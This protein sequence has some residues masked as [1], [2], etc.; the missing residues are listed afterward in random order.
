M[1]DLVSSV[2]DYLTRTD[3]ASS[4]TWGTDFEITLLAHMLDTIVYSYKAGQYWIACTPHG[5][6]HS[7]PENV[8]RKSIYIY[9]TGTHCKVVTGMLTDNS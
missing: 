6:D 1:V 8:N 2:D 3:M 9:Y 5:I 7:L 4:G